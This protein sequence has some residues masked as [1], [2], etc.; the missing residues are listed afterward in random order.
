[1]GGQLVFVYLPTW[2]RYRGEVNHDM[3]FQRAQVLEVVREL[4]LPLIDFHQVLVDHAD[5][6]SIFPF[7]LHGHYN[8]DGYRLLAKAIEPYL[9]GTEKQPHEMSYD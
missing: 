6:L 3:L 5:P 9:G 8:A 4:E 1:M 2:E 7:H